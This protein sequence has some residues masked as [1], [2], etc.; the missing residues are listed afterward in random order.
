[1]GETPAWMEFEDYKDGITGI[2]D[3]VDGRNARLEGVR[4]FERWDDTVLMRFA[5]G[6]ILR[7]LLP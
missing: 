5:D 7:G 4:G 3:H 1:M 2:N 6:D